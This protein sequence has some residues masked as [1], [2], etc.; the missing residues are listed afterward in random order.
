MSASTQVDPRTRTY[1]TANPATG[2]TL[3]DYEFISPEE[4]EAKLAKAD[5]AQKEWAKT[6]IA[7]RVRLFRRFADLFESKAEDFARQVT[8]EM[9]KPVAQSRDETS[10]AAAMFRYYADHG[11]EI[12][13]ETRGTVQTPA[14]PLETITRREP[15]GVILG[16]EP[17][18]GPMYQAMRAAAPNLFLGNAVLLKPAEICAGSTLMFD[19][20]F[21]EAGFPAGLF[22]TVLASVDQIS[23]YIAD[24][25]VRGVTLTGSDRPAL[26]LASRPVSRSSRWCWSSVVPMPSSSCPRPTSRPR[27]ASPPSAGWLSVARSACRRSE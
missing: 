10:M 16:I 6:P 7:E 23:T 2:E 3:K 11:P 4:A 21:L 25:R 22:Q 20:L 27:R 12:L 14:G 26:L 13:T 18:N 5:A 9:G 1:R 17:W 19:E 8:L 15:L 24:P